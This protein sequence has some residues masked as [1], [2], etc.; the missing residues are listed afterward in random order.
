MIPARNAEL[1]RIR[2]ERDAARA[3]IAEAHDVW[4]RS[5]QFGL[6]F[7]DRLVL[8]RILSRGVQEA[9]E[10]A[11][12]AVTIA[13]NEMTRQHRDRYLAAL[14][15]VCLLDITHG[16]NNSLDWH[17]CHRCTNTW[18]QNSVRPVCLSNLK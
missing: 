3:T 1:V 16:H 11:E 5:G 12:S 4:A 13:E 7:E 17:A 9:T 18:P 10:W 15:C 14:G 8:D 6:G 2:A